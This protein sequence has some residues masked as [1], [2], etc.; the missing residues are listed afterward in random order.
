VASAFTW[1]QC[2]VATVEAY[3]EALR[4]SRSTLAGS[5]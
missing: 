1:G 2:G 4:G 5:R 3:A